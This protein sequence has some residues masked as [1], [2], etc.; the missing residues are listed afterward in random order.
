[1]TY[2]WELE[3]GNIV[4]KESVCGEFRGKN[5][6]SSQSFFNVNCL[7]LIFLHPGIAATLD[8]CGPQF[9]FLHTAH[10]FP[11]ARARPRREERGAWSSLLIPCSSYAEENLVISTTS[12]MWFPLADL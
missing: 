7:S 11:H 4:P 2:R 3:F 6:E 5:P 1:M 12:R 10:F 9:L 8:S